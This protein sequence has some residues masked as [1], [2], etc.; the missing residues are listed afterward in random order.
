MMMPTCFLCFSPLNCTIS[1]ILFYEQHPM[2]YSPKSQSFVPLTK[3]QWDVARWNRCA[4]FY[5]SEW[6]PMYRPIYD[7]VVE[8]CVK[9]VKSEEYPSFLD[10]CSGA[11]EPS[12]SLAKRF[13]GAEIVSADLAAT[14][15]RV[16]KLRASKGFSTDQYLFAV[17]SE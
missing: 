13:P 1:F 3:R 17:E 16:G 7:R 9:E 2:V 11:G 6:M 5:A 4:P 15:I 8:Q 12:L 14:N 10:I